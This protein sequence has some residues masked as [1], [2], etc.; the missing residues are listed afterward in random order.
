MKVET[1][2]VFLIVDEFKK[3]IQELEAEGLIY[4]NTK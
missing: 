1:E 4:Q 2:N 3:K